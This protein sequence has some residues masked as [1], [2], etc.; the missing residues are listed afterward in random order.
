MGAELSG[1]SR[2]GFEAEGEALLVSAGSL[3]NKAAF[4]LISD[5]ILSI[6]NQF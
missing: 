3:D 2:G 4:L 1:A 5:S 6:S